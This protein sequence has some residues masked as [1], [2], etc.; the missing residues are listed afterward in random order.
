MISA[1]GKRSRVSRTISCWVALE[2]RGAR[3]LLFRQSRRALHAIRPTSVPVLLAACQ[4]VA[5]E[6]ARRV[7]WDET[8]SCRAQMHE[9]DV[10]LDMLKTGATL[11]R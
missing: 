8:R 1:P 5:G 11:L 10:V 9:M 7:R 6:R 3:R 2:L 4:K